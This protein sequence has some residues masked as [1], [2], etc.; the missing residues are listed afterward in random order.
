[1][2]MDRMM[3]VR[4]IMERGYRRDAVLS[5]FEDVPDVLD[6]ADEI[7]SP[8]TLGLLNKAI[9]PFKVVVLHPIRGALDGASEEIEHCTNCADMA[10]NVHFVPMAVSPL[11]LFWSG[12]SYPKKV[13][14]GGVDDINHGLT[15]FIREF[16]LEGRRIGDNVEVGILYGCVFSNE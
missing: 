13:G 10:M 5:I 8:H 14:I 1:M 12:H 3:M 16:W 2:R 4:R 11:L 7:A 6:V 9:E 15:V